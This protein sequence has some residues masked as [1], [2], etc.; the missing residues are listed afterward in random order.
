MHY[1]LLSI[2]NIPKHVIGYVAIVSAAIFA[3][4]LDIV[5]KPQ[6]HEISRVLK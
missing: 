2:Q 4:L 5:G 6:H 3:S 1:N